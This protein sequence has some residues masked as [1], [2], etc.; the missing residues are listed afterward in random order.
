M[1]IWILLNDA[2]LALLIFEKEG[3][4]KV[5][6]DGSNL[7]LIDGDSNPLKHEFFEQMK[8]VNKSK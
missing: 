7:W 8:N 4:L 6:L 3:L 1:F 2:K 5:D